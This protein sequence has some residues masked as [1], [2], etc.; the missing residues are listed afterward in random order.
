MLV[1]TRSLMVWISILLLSPQQLDSSPKRSIKDSLPEGWIEIKPGGGTTCARGDEFSFFVNPG[2]TNKVIVDF[3]G[4]GA[5]WNDYTCSKE[6]QTFTDSVDSLK[7]RAQA[8]LEGIYNRNN[9]LNPVKDWH[10]IIIPYCTGDIHWG[11]SQVN[12]KNESG[13]RFQISHNGAVNAKTVINWVRKKYRE[14]NTILTTGCSAGSYGSLYWTPQIRELFPKSNVIQ[15]GDGGAGVIT[16]EFLKTNFP[17][18]NANRNIPNWIPELDPESV[19]IYDLSM[20]DLYRIIG[21]HYPRI[22][23][24]Q[25]NS[26]F[27][28]NQTFFYELM[29][30]DPEDWANKMWLSQLTIRQKTSN[31]IDYIAPGEEHCILPYQRFYEIESQGVKFYDWFGHFVNQDHLSPIHCN[32]CEPS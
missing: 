25:Y 24:G 30:G 16:P 23:L 5:C 15:I 7:E 14:P 20:V 17:I 6:T 21:N 10:H 18:W 1:M 9:P 27:D 32:N 3:M 12:Y 13:Q 4:G 31:Y 29:G 2:T 22:R 8:G 26:A 11:H 28:E 19:S